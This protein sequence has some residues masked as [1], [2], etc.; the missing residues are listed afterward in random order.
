MFSIEGVVEFRSQCLKAS[1][2]KGEVPEG[3]S[4][5]RADP[6]QML[7]VA[8][9]LRIRPGYILRAYQFRQGG[10]GNGFVYAVPEVAPFPEPG[11]CPARSASHFLAPPIPP[12]ALSTIAEALEGDDSPWS[13]V[14]ASILARELR[15]LG[16]LWH[17]IVWGSHTILGANPIGAQC[18]KKARA[19]SRSY[20]LGKSS[21][22]RW[23]TP[24]K[25]STWT[26]HVI[27]SGTMRRVVFHTHSAHDQ[28][29]I[30][31]HE[32]EYHL[33]SYQFT[34]KQRRLA[35]GPGGFVF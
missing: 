16:A 13:F 23:L 2:S 11:D 17:G 25:P 30:Y 4:I 5:S 15:E 3:W 35:R 20:D 18:T 27:Q 34:E 9:S 28:Q 33:G 26:P 1:A 14:E 6:M 24:N 29:A 7:L 12:N 21:E 32:D 10:N 22:W 19:P 8:G 31:R